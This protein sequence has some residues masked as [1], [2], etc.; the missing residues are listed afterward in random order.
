MVALATPPDVEQLIRIVTAAVLRKRGLFDDFPDIAGKRNLVEDLVQHCMPRALQMHETFDP[1][2]T[3]PRK[4]LPDGRIPGYSTWITCG[5]HRSLVDLY[6]S[7]FAE[8]RR[9]DVLKSQARE[10]GDSETSALDEIRDW[11]ESG[12]T[13]GMP[14][15]AGGDDETLDEWLAKVYRFAVRVFPERQHPTRGNNWFTPAQI[16]CVALLM[17]KRGL[18]IRG[19]R[20]LLLESEDL[21]DAIKLSPMPA[22]WWFQMA[23]RRTAKYLRPQCD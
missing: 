16:V 12:E 10:L 18:S 3:K 21:R 19:A 11:F 15:G 1:S 20:M 7:R 13:A 23:V 22:H 17:R 9:I 8:S 5:V 14:G 4:P 2:K 6:K